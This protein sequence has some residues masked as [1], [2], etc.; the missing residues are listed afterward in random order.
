MPEFLVELY[1]PRTAADAVERSADR[2]RAGAERLTRE[3]TPVGFARS[4]FLPED[5]TC[6]LLY[7]SASMEAVRAAAER[8]GLRFERV[9]ELV[10]S[11]D[12]GSG[13]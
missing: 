13:G 1:L 9:V 10:T 3:G 6:F 8:V 11:A 2:A 7:E 12:G 5:E 4:I